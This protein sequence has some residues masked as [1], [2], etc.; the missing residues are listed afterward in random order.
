VACTYN[1]KAV[2]RVFGLTGYYRRF[3]K[4]YA[5]ISQ[6]L[7]MLLKKNAFQWNSQAQEAFKRL[8]QAMVQ[9]LVL[10]LPNFE[11]EFFIK[12]NASGIGL[13]AVLQQ[14][15]HPIAYLSKT[16]APK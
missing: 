10:A 14:N 13:G 4:G 16:L 7:T 2:K 11:E 12:T 9:S 3:I 8:Q 1:L 15:K 6:P 5:T